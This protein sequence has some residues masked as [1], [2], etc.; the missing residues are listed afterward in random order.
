MEN[1]FTAD[2]FSGNRARLQDLFTGTAPIVV[3]A[4]GV[5]QRSADTTYPFTQDRDFW[6]LTGLDIADAILVI[7][8]TKDYIILPE[9]RQEQLLNNNHTNH[10]FRELADIVN[11]YRLP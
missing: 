8:R 1:E 3:T 5:L 11:L 9:L 6:Y 7:D 2:F 4:N 10:Q